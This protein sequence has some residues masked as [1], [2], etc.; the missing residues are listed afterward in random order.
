MPQ[1]SNI[2]FRPRHRAL[3]FDPK[4]RR[5]GLP[6]HHSR[7]TGRGTVRA[8]PR[9]VEEAIRDLLVGRQPQCPEDGLE[10]EQLLHLRPSR[11]DTSRQRG[12]SVWATEDLAVCVPKMSMRSGI[13]VAEE[14]LPVRPR[15]TSGV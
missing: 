12:A 5:T 1:R 10:L 2:R 6:S 15:Q 13:R 3:L 8:S 7:S 11:G 14:R 9:R 4:W